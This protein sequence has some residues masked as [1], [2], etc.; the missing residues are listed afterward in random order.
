[1][2]EVYKKQNTQLEVVLGKYGLNTTKVA[3][4]TQYRQQVH[5]VSGKMSKGAEPKF[6]YKMGLG[7][8]L[9]ELQSMIDVLDKCHK[10]QLNY[11]EFGEY[12][13]YKGQ[14]NR[15]VLKTSD[16]GG[17]VAIKLQRVSTPDEFAD[18]DPLESCDPDP[19]NTDDVIISGVVVD[20]NEC[21]EKFYISKNEDWKVLAR[22]LRDFSGQLSE[23][24]SDDDVTT[25][26]IAPPPPPPMPTPPPT[27]T[28][29][30]TGENRVVTTPKTSWTVTPTDKGGK[31]KGGAIDKKP[32]KPKKTK[33]TV[34]IVDGEGESEV[35][36]N[37]LPEQQ[38]QLAP[39]TYPN[40]LSLQFPF[41]FT[42]IGKN[43]KHLKLVK[44]LF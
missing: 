7:M 25:T 39:T 6:L 31:R 9:D 12:T 15:L 18:D 21:F 30:I 20:W 14:V 33:P 37:N 19:T 24:W 23:L 29:T 11:H 10:D 34:E 8:K 32:K 16:Y 27:P 13:D 35:R 42:N 43:L 41:P 1:M 38:Q 36:R 3:F 26:P 22:K 5:L 40:K 4:A 28:T 2:A 44:V 17:L